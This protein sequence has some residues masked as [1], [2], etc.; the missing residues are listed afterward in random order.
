MTDQ[1]KKKANI[2]QPPNKLKQMAGEGGLD[3]QTIQQAECAL[4]D[5]AKRN[6]RCVDHYIAAIKLH[7]KYI[8][9]IPTDQWDDEMYSDI[10]AL[11]LDIKSQGTLIG[12]PLITQVSDILITFMETIHK[13]DPKVVAIIEKF[14]DALEQLSQRDEHHANENKDILEKQLI[15]K[16]YGSCHE[17]MRKA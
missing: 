12:C 16:L 4:T 17:Y 11:A 2:I 1:K 10:L 15:K 7:L 9:K 6:A 8:N 5:T 14:D 13:L 3:P